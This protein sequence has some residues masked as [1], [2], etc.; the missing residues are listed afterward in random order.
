[1]EGEEVYMR[2]SHPGFYPPLPPL[3][4]P[5]SRY[6]SQNPAWLVFRSHFASDSTL[7]SSE[8][9]PT[10]PLSHPACVISR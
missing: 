4:S 8:I 1:V 9:A 2:V 7:L 5:R 10:P 6:G 3:P